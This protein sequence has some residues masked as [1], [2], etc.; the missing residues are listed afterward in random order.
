MTPLR[1]LLPD[2]LVPVAGELAALLGVPFTVVSAAP[3][4]DGPAHRI[5]QV[6]LPALHARAFSDAAGLRG[7]SVET[8]VAGWIERGRAELAG[9]DEPS[10]L[11]TCRLLAEWER[12]GYRGGEPPVR[13]LARDLAR[14]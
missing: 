5:V 9:D 8:L 13:D 12:L 2:D 4:W 10:V 6:D 3:A 7:V 1:I 14:P 11:R